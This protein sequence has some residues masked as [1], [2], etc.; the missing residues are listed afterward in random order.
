M[1]SLKSMA[2]TMLA[3]IQTRV[4][5]LSCEMAEERLRIEQMLLYSSVTLFFFGL[6]IMLLTVFIVVAFWDNYR[7]LV[8]GGLATLFFVAGLISLVIL[9]RIAEHKT[10]LFSSSIGALADDRSNLATQS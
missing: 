9:R 4:E 5:L 10:N 6:S 7:L 3:I 1:E 2:G 8:L